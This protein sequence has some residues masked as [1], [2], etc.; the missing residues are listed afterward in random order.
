MASVSEVT[1]NLSGLKVSAAD[2]ENKGA[3]QQ[4]V[5]RTLLATHAL[6]R[7]ARNAS[8]GMAQAFAWRNCPYTQH[9][10]RHGR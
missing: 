10:L 7:P 5:W 8:P 6:C 3:N 9:V 4:Q 1:G 2:A